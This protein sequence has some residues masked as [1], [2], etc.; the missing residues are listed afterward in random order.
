[1]SGFGGGFGGFGQNNNTQQSSTFGGFG[2]ANTNTNTGTSLLLIYALL[3]SIRP[4][5][6]DQLGEFWRS[7][8]IHH[9]LGFF[10]LA[11]AL[12]HLRTLEALDQ[13]RIQ[14]AVDCLVVAHPLEAL[15]I[16]EV[17]RERSPFLDLS[18]GLV[19]AP[20]VLDCCLKNERSDL[21][22]PIPSCG[23]T[24]SLLSSKHEQP[25][26]RI[27]SRFVKTVSRS[28]ANINN[29]RRLRSQHEQ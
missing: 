29:Y 9:L 19:F 12:A 20:H 3:R 7:P 15:E 26:S 2:G 17:C 10:F 21:S 4:R 6:M 22:A 28:N 5:K 13:T 27:F 11:Q 1:M 18:P 23:S 16:L 14:L 25:S 8:R 24:K